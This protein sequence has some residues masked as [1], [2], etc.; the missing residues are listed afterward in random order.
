[1]TT[2]VALLRAINLPS[3]GKVGMA[4]LR[5]WLER[6]GFRD[7]RSLL[8]TGNL[9]FTDPGR[10]GPELERRLETEAARRLHLETAFLVRTAAEWDG[11]VARNPF[12]REART[13]PA[14]LL[15]MPLKRAPGPAEAAALQ[16][17]IT[18]RET[19]QVDGRE[20]YLVY[21]DGIGRSRLTLKLIERKLGTQ[22]T[23]RN[24]N[25][26]LKIAAL[27]AT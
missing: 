23:A 16:A 5:A 22:G 9:V 27:A 1:M 13:D 4:E 25:T 18:G 21:P 20:A 14:H 17:A 3:H 8:Q 2:H 6:L 11:I 26:V 7:V 12:P 19:A 24:W 10:G 15:V